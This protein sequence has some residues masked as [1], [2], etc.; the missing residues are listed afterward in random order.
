MVIKESLMTETQLEK[1]NK[2]FTET[3]L[4]LY[5][6]KH[7]LLYSAMQ[8]RFTLPKRTNRSK[9]KMKR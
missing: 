8:T 5:C 7:N 2:S 9:M 6:T 4:L 3:K 1:E